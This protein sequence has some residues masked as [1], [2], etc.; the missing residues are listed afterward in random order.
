M[1]VAGD[2]AITY[3]VGFALKVRSQADVV[4]TSH[5]LLAHPL[6]V[7]VKSSRAGGLR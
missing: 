6:A 4:L 5:T 1:T 2:V 3:L 7:H